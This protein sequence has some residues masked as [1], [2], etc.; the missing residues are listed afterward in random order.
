VCLFSEFVIRKGGPAA[1]GLFRLSG[2]AVT[3]RQTI[4]VVNRGRDSVVTFDQLGINDWAAL[5]K[6][7]SHSLPE[8]II[9]I[10]NFNHLK[11]V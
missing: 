4:A 3:V 8:R 10:D 9:S 11:T 1:V 5:F 7:E 6:A 2:N